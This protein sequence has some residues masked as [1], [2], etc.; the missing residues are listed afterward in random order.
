MS[1]SL[2]KYDFRCFHIERR[3][4]FCQNYM[5][6]T[7]ITFSNHWKFNNVICSPMFTLF[8][9]SLWSLTMNCTIHKNILTKTTKIK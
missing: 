7:F 2:R 8:T 5:N 4:T 6:F 3:S 1:K 9:Y